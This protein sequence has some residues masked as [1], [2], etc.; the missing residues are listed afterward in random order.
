[1]TI[2]RRAA[3]AIVGFIAIVLAITWMMDAQSADRYFELA[4]WGSEATLELRQDAGGGI[5]FAPGTRYV[6]PPLGAAREDVY[7]LDRTGLE[8][9]PLGSPAWNA[10]PGE[11]L[12]CDRAGLVTGVGLD[13][14]ELRFE[15]RSVPVPGRVLQAR[16]SP[17]GRVVAALSARGVPIPAV[18]LIPTLGRSAVLGWRYHHFLAFPSGK[19]IGSPVSL[20]FGIADPMLCWSPRGDMVIYFDHAFTE[21]ALVRVRE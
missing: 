19:E 2:Q 17:D 5:L 1:M 12:P 21:V 3:V 8:L 4:G 13:S 18:R 11:V 16:I 20:G 15:G 7:R 9:T 10:A 14:G 6:D